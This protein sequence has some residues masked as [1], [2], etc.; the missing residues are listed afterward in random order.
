MILAANILLA[1]GIADLLRTHV[2]RSVQPI[3]FGVAAVVLLLLGAASESALPALAGIVVAV[4]WIFAMPLR[5][6]PRLGLWPAGI[7]AAIAIA[8]VVWSPRSPALGVIGD[9]WILIAPTGPVPFG[10]ALLAAG[11]AVVLLETGN[12]IVR[13]ALASENA[14]LPAE[15]SSTEPSTVQTSSEDAM[16]GDTAPGSP[17]PVPTAPASGFRGG[18][19]IGPLERI[20]V[21]MLTLV[22][23]YPLL[24]AMLAAKGIVRFPEISRDR[25]SGAGAEYFLVGSLVSWVT[26]LGGAFLLWWA[27]STGMPR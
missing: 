27:A 8:A 16:T 10:L 25:K 7:L 6:R 19:L 13:A 9:S 11:I 23:A 26:A 4:G 15:L 18:R 21:L 12:V 1:V 3:A 20:L 22:A 5:R 17:A 14:Q 24:A 2:R